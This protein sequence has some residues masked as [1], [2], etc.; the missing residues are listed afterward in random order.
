MT[1]YSE[2][3]AFA[4]LLLLNMEVFRRSRHILRDRSHHG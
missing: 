4:I 2:A 1:P 3:L